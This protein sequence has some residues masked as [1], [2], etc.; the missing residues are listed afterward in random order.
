MIYRLDEKIAQKLSEFYD[1]ETGE[2]L[3]GV[4]EEDM[5]TEIGQIEADHEVLLDSIAS[6]IKN[7]YAEA[8]GVKAVKMALADRQSKLE[9]RMERDKRLLAYLLGGDAWKNDRH[10]VSFRRSE[11]L[12]VDDSAALLN[13]AKTEGR[14]FLKEPEI[15]L[16]DIKMAVKKGTVIP[17]VHLE[18]TNSIQV[19]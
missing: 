17:A 11:K 1:S 19:K 14:G 9:K 16:N 6:E 8:Q 18:Q 5:L 2:I 7:L 3:D 10:V 12:V 4:T 15:M 13:W